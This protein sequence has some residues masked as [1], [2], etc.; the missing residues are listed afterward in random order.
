LTTAGYRRSV[1]RADCR[2]RSPDAVTV[3]ISRAA[4]RRLGAVKARVISTVTA[5]GERRRQSARITLR[6]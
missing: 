3:L 1:M 5:S 2:R 4:K 6:R